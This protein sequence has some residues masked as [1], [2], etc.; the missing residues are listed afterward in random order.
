MSKTK[1]FEKKK[2]KRLN[3][4]RAEQQRPHK[5]PSSGHVLS[6]PPKVQ[7]QR[8]T[9]KLPGERKSSTHPRPET[10]ER[11]LKRRE[12]PTSSASASGQRDTGETPPAQT[13]AHPSR[14]N[15]APL[16]RDRRLGA[17]AC[18]SSR[19]ALAPCGCPPGISRGLFSA[20]DPRGSCDPDLHLGPMLPGA[21]GWAHRGR[22]S[23]PH[24]AGRPQLRD[25]RAPGPPRQGSWKPRAEVSACQGAGAG[26]GGHARSRLEPV[27]CGRRR[28]GEHLLQVQRRPTPGLRGQDSTSCLGTGWGLTLT[29]HPQRPPFLDVKHPPRLGPRGSPGVQGP[30]E[31]WRGGVAVKALGRLR[32][33]SFTG[34]T[35]SGR[36]AGSPGRPAP[37]LPF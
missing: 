15:R 3:Q 21:L 18:S 36:D 34:S 9:R 28:P 25:L 35:R 31:P 33:L 23:S 22:D 8:G 1:Q 29:L 13:R 7:K 27:L 14:P 5:N 19:A 10:G 37:L 2:C 11:A 12:R 30:R 32:R 16:C 4:A 17:L 6:S 26:T 24:P 20:L